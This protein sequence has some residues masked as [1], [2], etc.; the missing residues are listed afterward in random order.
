MNGP[1]FELAAAVAG[2]KRSGR[3]G[4][5]IFAAFAGGLCGLLVWGVVTSG[6]LWRRF[7]AQY[8]GEEISESAA[9]AVAEEDRENAAVMPTERPGLH[10]AASGRGGGEGVP[11][12]DTQRICVSNVAAAADH[13]GLFQFAVRA[14]IGVEGTFTET[15]AVFP[16]NHGVS[17]FDFAVAG[18]QLV[19]V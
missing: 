10:F 2:G 14:G 11:V 4:L 3:S 5:P 6:F 17:D 1:L 18:V 12:S 7:A 16:R 15:G 13:G 19:C 9:P 8:C